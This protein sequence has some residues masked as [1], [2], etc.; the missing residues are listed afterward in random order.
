MLWQRRLKERDQSQRESAVAEAVM[1]DFLVSRTDEVC[2][3]EIPGTGGV[4]FGFAVAG[5]SFCVEVTNISIEAAT[6]ATGLQERPS[7]NGFHKLLTKSVRSQV[8]QKLQQVRT[9]QCPT[10]VAVTTL[11]STAS[12]IC[13]S[14]PAIEKVMGSPPRITGNFNV[15]S[16]EV[17]G[18]LYQTTD[19]QTSVFLSPH[20]ILGPDGE[21]IVQAKFQPISGFLLCGFGV[22]PHHGQVLGGLN[23]EAKYPFD[24][25]LLA[26]VPFCSF[27]TWPARD[28]INFEWT[29][30]KEELARREQCAATRRLESDPEFHG[31]AREIRAGLHGESGP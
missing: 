11:H 9:T 2:L 13:I 30:T 3:V 17:E 27:G 19:L 22:A 18:D 7:V 20:P 26:D 4:D 10:L 16:G 12:V 24:P 29:I 15:T 28:S 14:H 5:E 1:W 25:R 21:P 31:L 6:R 8:R 23:P